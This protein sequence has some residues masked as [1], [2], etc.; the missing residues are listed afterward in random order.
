M[1]TLVRDPE[2]EYEEELELEAELEAEFESPAFRL[3]CPAGCTV[4]GRNLGPAACQ[5]TL[6]QDITRA[7]G[8]ANRAAALL[9]ASPRTSPTSRIYLQIFGHRPQRAVPWA[10]GH[11]SGAITA[12]RFRMAA[13]SLTRRVIHFICQPQ[14]GFPSTNA[15]VPFNNAAGRPNRTD[16]WLFPQ[17]WGNSAALRAGILV[18]ETLHLIF[19]PMIVDQD[20]ATARRVNAHCYEWLVVRLNGHTPDPADFTACRMTPP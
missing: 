3:A 10:P 16:I 15:A 17:Y 2:V 18:H 20:T 13:D 1:R 4:G 14:A 8:F 9:E 11:D 7:V 19:L 5:A 6:R 12:R